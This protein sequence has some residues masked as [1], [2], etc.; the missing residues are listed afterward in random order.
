MDKPTITFEEFLDT[1]QRV[2]EPSKHPSERKGQSLMNY[3]W[4]VWPEEYRRIT[5][6]DVDCFYRDD[7]IPKTIEHLQQIWK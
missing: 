6:T 3:L 1:W 5:A 4:T 7:L 2:V